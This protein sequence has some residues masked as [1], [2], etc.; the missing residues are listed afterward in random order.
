MPRSRFHA[1]VARATGES[2]HTVLRRGFSVLRL[3]VPLKPAPQ[4][5]LACPG[6]GSEVAVEVTMGGIRPDWAECDACDIAYPYDDQ[7]LFL[8]DEEL[9]ASA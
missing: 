5:C 8:P 3:E 9:A 4:L 2:V 1:D 6:C 7:E